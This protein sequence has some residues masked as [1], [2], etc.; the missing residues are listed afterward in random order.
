MKPL[1]K[2]IMQVIKY[3]PS[4]STTKLYDYFPKKQH[5]AVEE[6]LRRLIVGGD[7]TLTSDRK[8]VLP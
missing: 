6:S 7:V 2:L 5:R 4:I 1:D 8:L 3:N